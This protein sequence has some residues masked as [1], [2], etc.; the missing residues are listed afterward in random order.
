MT[1]TSVIHMPEHTCV[2][3]PQRHVHNPHPHIYTYMYKGRE[4]NLNCQF[5][6]FQS[7]VGVAVPQ[8]AIVRQNVMGEGYDGAELLTSGQ[9]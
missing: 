1:S 3:A 4:T 9:P 8:W 5:W 6:S 2:C 7:V